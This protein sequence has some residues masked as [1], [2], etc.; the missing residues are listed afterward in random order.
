MVTFIVFLRGRATNDRLAAAW[1]HAVADSITANFAHFGTL[2]DPSLALEKISFNDYYYYA[3]GRQHC[4]Y[5]LF[6]ID[7]RKRQCLFSTLT[8]ELI[9]PKR[10]LVHIEV[11]IKLEEAPPVEF[12]ICRK[13]NMK[14]VFANMAHLKNFVGPVLPES[15]K[16]HSDCGLVVL[17]ESDDAAN[18]IVDN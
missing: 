9:W 13:K 1:N 6:K 10:D 2:K 18:H 7:L 11:P 4:M 17:A 14:Q 15:L 5:A 16:G 8:M 12:Y 3:S